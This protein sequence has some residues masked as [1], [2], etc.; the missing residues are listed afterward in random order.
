MHALHPHRHGDVA[1]VKP[2][3]IAVA[4]DRQIGAEST[5]HQRTADYVSEGALLVSGGLEG[6]A[7]FAED[8]HGKDHCRPVNEM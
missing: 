3:A 7:D 8:V 2:K 5:F 4:I 1:W 6:A